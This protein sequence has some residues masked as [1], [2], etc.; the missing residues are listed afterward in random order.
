MRRPYIS[1]LIKSVG[2]DI[3]LKELIKRINLTYRIDW[4]KS[5]S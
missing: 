2:M 5:I 1:S 3:N 4:E